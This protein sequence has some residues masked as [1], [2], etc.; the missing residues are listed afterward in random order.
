[1]DT[2]YTSVTWTAGDIITEAKMDN[3]V[4]NDRAI[5]SMNNGV[6]MADRADPATPPAGQLHVYVK[7]KSGTSAL[8]FMDDSGAVYQLGD[9]TPTF[10]FPVPGT[11]IVGTSLTAAI[12]VPKPLTIVKAYAYVKTA[13]TGTPIIVDI[14]KNNSS[15]WASTPSNRLQ[16]GVSTQTGSQTAFDVTSLAEFDILTLDIVQIGS[17]IAGAD[18][19][20]ALKTQ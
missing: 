5:D 13:P 7:D 16:V 12:I 11:L 2:L 20:V 15:I 17:G 9:V 8:Y 14:K 3:M 18:L 4:A 10:E 1:M 6:R 19:T